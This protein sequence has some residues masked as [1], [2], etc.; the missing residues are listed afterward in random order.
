[1]DAT[2]YIVEGIKYSDGTLDTWDT[3]ATEYAVMGLTHLAEDQP[4]LVELR[5]EFARLID[6]LPLDVQIELEST[7]NDTWIK[8][9]DAVGRIV[10]EDEASVV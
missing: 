5:A 7:Y 1:M 6:P 3:T 10:L 2:R 8:T 9:A 4:E